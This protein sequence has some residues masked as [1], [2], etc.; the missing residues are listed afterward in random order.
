MS[1]PE[2]QLDVQVLNSPISN[3]SDDV[4]WS[5]FYSGSAMTE[6]TESTAPVFRTLLHCSHVCCR[7]RNLINSSPV[8][9]GRVINIKYLMNQSWREEIMRRTGNASL[10][11]TASQLCIITQYGSP[12]PNSN[13]QPAT[14]TISLI[15]FLL[16]YWE[17]IRYLDVRI[18]SGNYSGFLAQFQHLLVRP[19]PVLEKFSLEMP[20]NAERWWSDMTP[21]KV[22][23][24]Q[25]P[26]LKQFF[27]SNVTIS[28]TTPWL[29]HIREFGLSGFVRID[30]L[31]QALASM[32][33]L[34]TL[35][36]ARGSLTYFEFALESPLPKVRLPSL[37][38]VIVN[39][40]AIDLRPYLEF[41]TRAS[42]SKPCYVQLTM[43]SSGHSEDT[44][45]RLNYSDTAADILRV[46]PEFCQLS[47][48]TYIGLSSKK[49]TTTD[50]N[51]GLSFRDDWGVT[52]DI[53]LSAPF[54]CPARKR[55]QNLLRTALM[56]TRI[57]GVQELSFFPSMDGTRALFTDLDIFYRIC[58]TKTLR[59]SPYGIQCLVD[60][61]KKGSG[62]STIL[63]A[64]HTI[65]LD[66]VPQVM[67]IP[68]MKLFFDWRMSVW[69]D[70]KL[71]LLHMSASDLSFCIPTLPNA[72]GDPSPDEWAQAIYEAKA[73]A[74]LH[75]F[76]GMR[77]IV[78]YSIVV[79]NEQTQARLDFLCR[80]SGRS[81]VRRESS[82]NLPQASRHLEEGTSGS[83]RAY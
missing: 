23:D 37:K 54:G 68:S 19:A 31:L 63:P 35:R 36:D 83:S 21:G 12:P 27:A 67:E 5:I 79:G 8:L 41:F 50:Y 10:S 74:W 49:P 44:M 69:S 42:P 32:P 72:L 52:L 26:R 56:S 4:L 46:L 62:S 80:G 76:T 22:F 75:Q 43:N 47:N 9:W 81:Q 66:A 11:I 82:L 13:P 2:S 15:P 57:H 18:L 24:N 14:R 77:V 16:P 70:A 25:A 65:I 73:V 64:L 71:K 39:T 53:H 40:K 33:S 29:R 55:L 6:E 34:E 60:F 30:W 17:R 45:R 51:A 58:W 20:S 78:D 61:D 28:P 48:V 7:W 3:L 1:E 38:N 59:T